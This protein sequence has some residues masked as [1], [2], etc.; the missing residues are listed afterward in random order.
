MWTPVE[1]AEA[2]ELVHAARPDVVVNTGD[3]LQEEPPIEKVGHVASRFL[4]GQHPAVSGPANL[5]VLGNHDYYAGDENVAELS[6]HLES[7]GVCMLVNRGAC[8]VSWSQGVSF[9]GLTDDAPGFD[10][11]VAALLSSARPRIALVHEPDLAERLPPGCADLVLAGHT[12]GGQI[13]LPGM[14][15]FIT[16]RFAKSNYVEGLYRIN[17]MP[18]YVNRGLGCSGL[19]IRFRAR[20]EVA[21]IRLVR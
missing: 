15:P 9:V 4:L 1:A 12:H 21:L 3:Y 16:R 8:V 7:L 19:P 5:A 14:K 6:A 13:T 10:G 18:V 11:A 17:E 2:A 20:P